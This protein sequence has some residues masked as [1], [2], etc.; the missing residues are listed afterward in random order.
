MTKNSQ[1]ETIIFIEK[2]SMVS[3]KHMDKQTHQGKRKKQLKLP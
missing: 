2:Y 1:L 3:T